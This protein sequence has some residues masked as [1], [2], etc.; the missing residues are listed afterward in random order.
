MTAVRA[1]VV[2]IFRPWQLILGCCAASYSSFRK[3]VLPEVGT[4]GSLKN[5]LY[6]LEAVIIQSYGSI[7]GWQR[8]MDPPC[9]VMWKWSEHLFYQQGQ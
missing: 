4:S 2:R 9:I 6:V 3:A 5:P 1:A 8:V 7:E